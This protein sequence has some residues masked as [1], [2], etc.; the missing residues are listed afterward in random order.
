L[1]PLR[2]PIEA[3]KVPP[4]VSM[5]VFREGPGKKK[6]GT[7]SVPMGVHKKRAWK[8]KRRY[9]FCL[10]KRKEISKKNQRII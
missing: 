6:E 3:L 2:G 7:V 8:G 9:G 4:G 10:R 1:G 5:G